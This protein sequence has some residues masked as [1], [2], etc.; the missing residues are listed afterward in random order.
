[1]VLLLQAKDV[2]GFLC[3]VPDDQKTRLLA[4]QW[5]IPS[6]IKELR[7]SESDSHALSTLDPQ[8][9]K[10]ES[11]LA[12]TNSLLGKAFIPLIRVVDSLANS[13][14]PAVVDESHKVK[15][16]KDVFMDGDLSSDNLPPPYPSR[17]SPLLFYVI[18]HQLSLTY[19]YLTSTHYYD[20][21]CP[22]QS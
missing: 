19:R 18:L 8:S 7:V 17:H 12:Q 21:E 3:M 11:K 1:M 10:M 13:D 16:Y 4:E 2:R 6:N 15:I 5:S 9:C 22:V 14:N 20:S